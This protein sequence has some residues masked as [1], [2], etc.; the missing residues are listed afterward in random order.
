MNAPK[1]D[2]LSAPTR[3]AGSG[4][5]IGWSISMK[6]ITH[7]LATVLL[8]SGLLAACSTEAGTET[9]RRQEQMQENRS[10]MNAADTKREW[11]KERDEAMK[12]LADLRENMA[13]R[14]ERERKRLADGIKDAEKRVECERHI[15]ELE[16]NIAR[17]D[18][19]TTGMST[20]TADNWDSMK[21]DMRKATDETKS[22]WE[23]QK[24]WVDQQTDADKDQDGH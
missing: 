20:A 7:Q 24:D 2:R 6:N 18:A 23:R 13:D 21:R 9:E 8:S 17:I 10:E 12:E 11:M 4:T 1:S 3:F 22:W 16:Q 19:S 14:L 5:M 15:A